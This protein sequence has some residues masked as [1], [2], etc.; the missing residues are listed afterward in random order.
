ML[1]RLLP[2]AIA[3]A[4]VL[5]A[6]VYV[7]ASAN[8][9]LATGSPARP[10]CTIS[11]GLAA[12]GPSDAVLVRPGTYPETLLVAR[13]ARIVGIGGAAST[14]IDGGGAGSVITNQGARLEL[15]GLTIEGGLASSGGGVQSMQGDLEMRGCVVT[16]NTASG[17][18]QLRGAGGLRVQGGRVLLDE[19]VFL[20]NESLSAPGAAGFAGGL[21]VDGATEVTIRRCTFE[22][23]LAWQIAAASITDS[24]PTTIEGTTFE[25]NETVSACDPTILLR[26]N[27]SFALR[28]CTFARG[29]FG[30]GLVISVSGAQSGTIEHC[31][32]DGLC[33]I[34]LTIRAE[35]G[36]SGAVEVSNSVFAG[37]IG[38]DLIGPGSAQVVS[39]GHNV[40]EADMP[41][42]SGWMNGVNGDQI[43]VGDAG[44]GEP[45]DNGGPTRTIPLVDGSPA[46]G[47]AS[48][49]SSVSA[50]Q[51]GVLR[52]GSQRDSGA[53]EATRA[54]SVSICAAVPNSTA[55][56][57]VLEVTGDQLVPSGALALTAHSLP[58][59]VACLFI[60]SRAA[61]LVPQP[62]GSAGNLC[63]G[64]SIGRFLRPGQLGFADAAGLRSLE[65][66]PTAFPQGAGTIS[67]QPG[68]TWVFQ[69]WHRD[70]IGGTATSNF[71]DAAALLFL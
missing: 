51:R 59:G 40:I 56:A 69:A 30:E 54:S 64:G 62:G 9:G 10:F 28:N 24:G 44:L 22:G 29:R 7:D 4:P 66:D 31:T 38:P 34:P 1:A 20:D 21:L 33:A 8:C 58:P 17:D 32:V 23:N 13:D 2:L 19:V 41:N 27:Q 63:L 53:F 71:T 55:R 15:Q 36:S 65:V 3:C 50:D 48:S 57:G 11:E 42:L 45:G 26:T 39:G 6:D 61:A 37:W 52:V 46:I 16:A 70:V 43:G 5:G 68:E 25:D 47:G 14:V 18:A 12:A 35:A 60:A 67:A 49:T